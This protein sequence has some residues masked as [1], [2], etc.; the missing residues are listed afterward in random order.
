MLALD[1]IAENFKEF[2]RKVKLFVEKAPLPRWAK[3]DL[4]EMVDDHKEVK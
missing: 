4:Q 3:E 2:Y 1:K